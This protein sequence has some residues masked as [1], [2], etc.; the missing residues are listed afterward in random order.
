MAPTVLRYAA[1]VY[2]ATAVFDFAAQPMTE[3]HRHFTS[4]DYTFTVLLV[5]FVL[6][7]LATV[8]VLHRLHNGSDG[9]LG[10]RAV[11]VTTVAVVAFAA[12]GVITLI[13]N[14]TRSGPPLYPLAVL[15]SLVGFGM[16]AVAFRRAGRLASW[17]GPALLLGW[18]FGGPVAEGGTPGFRGAALIQAAISV[19]V[20][21]SV[22]R[23]VGTT[24]ITQSRHAES[25]LTTSR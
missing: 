9:R 20:A 25:A 18:I 12:A 13:T 1:A 4:A 5:P 16:L 11:V 19:A 10:H 2:A 15:A 22:A 7:A 6:A 17:V 21:A 23:T 14:D 3:G 24:T 8:V